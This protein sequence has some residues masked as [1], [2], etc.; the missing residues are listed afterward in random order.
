MTNLKWGKMNRVRIV[1]TLLVILLASTLVSANNSTGVTITVSTLPQPTSTPTSSSSG[2]SGTGG[3]G[4]ISDELFSNIESSDR[5]EKDWFYERPVTYKFKYDVYEVT[6][7][8]LTSENDVSMKFELLKNIS[9]KVTKKPD[10]DVY[11]YFNLNSGSKRFKNAIV[12]FKVNSSWNMD[13]INL[14]RW[15]GKEWIQLS[16][17]ETQTN[18]STIRYFE[19]TTD[20]FSNFAIIGYKFAALPTLTPTSVITEQPTPVTI[21]TTVVTPLQTNVDDSKP[22][23]VSSITIIII[24][25]L[26]TMIIIGVSVW[27][28]RR[29]K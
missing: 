28:L 1:T 9:I 27:Y 19:S 12:R 6:V 23:N 11:K 4:V 20:G 22:K 24:I 7:N 13:L 26:L 16:T 3:G 18:D 10:S 29:A 14:V 17:I 25:L 5:V 8:S 2:S 15:N 21:Q